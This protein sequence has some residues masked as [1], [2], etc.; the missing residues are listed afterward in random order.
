MPDFEESSLCSWLSK[1]QKARGLCE[2]AQGARMAEWGLLP[3]VWRI[4]LPGC[5]QRCDGQTQQ[6][7]PPVVSLGLCDFG[8]D[9]EAQGFCFVL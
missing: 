6:R 5:F 4:T 9:D 7:M 8:L 3:L 2:V 1:S